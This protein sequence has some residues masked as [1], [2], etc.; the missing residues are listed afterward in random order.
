[1]TQPRKRHGLR[2]TAGQGHALNSKGAPRPPLTAES[3]L[4]I[5]HGV[6]TF[7]ALQGICAKYIV[8]HQ[9]ISNV[10]ARPACTCRLDLDSYDQWLEHVT[11]LQA[12]HIA[13][14]IQLAR[15]QDQS[16]L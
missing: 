9:L 14:A 10:D 15:N 16:A 12:S 3:S 13:M 8:E 5:L 11:E 6:P 2:R 1:M 4:Q 7:K